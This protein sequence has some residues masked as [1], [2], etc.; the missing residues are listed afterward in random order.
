MQFVPDSW[1]QDLGTTILVPR[2]WYL[3]PGNRLSVPRPSYQDLGIQILVP[4]SCYQ[5]FSTKIWYQKILAPRP[6][7]RDSGTKN[8]CKTVQQRDRTECV[9]RNKLFDATCS[10]DPWNGMWNQGMASHETALSNTKAPNSQA[11]S[12]NSRL[13]L[14]QT[15]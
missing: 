15:A 8:I 9:T 2:I 13:L 7:Y 6:W 5:D 10:G 1:Y 4:E 11:T 3:D 14:N 12:E